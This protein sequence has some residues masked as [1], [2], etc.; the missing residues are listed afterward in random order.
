MIEAA[1]IL[2]LRT[3]LEVF[4]DRAYEPDGRLVSRAT[5]GAVI[6]EVDAVVARAVALVTTHQVAALDG[7][8]L[9]LDAD[10]I[11]VHGD[12]PGAGHLAAALRAGLE[13]AGVSVLPLG[14]P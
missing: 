8:R 7:S 9:E 5:R 6:H 10:T 14:A 3:A 2:G 12:T 13:A 11:C 4:A 1:R